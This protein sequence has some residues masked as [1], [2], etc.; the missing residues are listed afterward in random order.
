MIT[1]FGVVRANGCYWCSEPGCL[2]NG[3]PTPTP[4][5]DSF[6][7]R[8]FV[9]GRGS[10]FYLVLEAKP[11][12]GG[13][14]V[15]TFV[16][17][18]TPGAGVYPS[19]QVL[20][21]RSLGN[22][23]PTICDTQPVA[24]GGGGVPGFLV[25][26]FGVDK[27]DALVDFA[28]RFNAHLPSEPCTLGPDGLDGTI[29]ANLPSGGRQFCA[30]VSANIAFPSGDTVLTARVADTAGRPGPVVEIVVRRQP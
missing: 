4:V 27:A 18:P 19:L 15:G 26:D 23:S 14:T 20:S 6:G 29:T 7:R 17:S 5:Y 12:S 24:Q 16:P 21:S 8:V 10:G 25:P 9:V 30:I 11:G 28:C 13:G 3:S 1:F 22:G 2:C